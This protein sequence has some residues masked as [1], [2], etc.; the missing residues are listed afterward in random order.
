LTKSFPRLFRNQDLHRK[1][2]DALAQTAAAHR[3]VTLF[4]RR[5][6][7]GIIRAILLLHD[8]IV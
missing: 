5:I 4:M 6:A 2:R 1:L 7:G 8:L 3:L